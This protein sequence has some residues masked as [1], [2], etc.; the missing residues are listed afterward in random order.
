MGGGER[1][2]GCVFNCIIRSFHHI[3]NYY[4]YIRRIVLTEDENL[5]ESSIE[6]ES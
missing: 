2:M 4:L 6:G 1:V 5:G 3:T